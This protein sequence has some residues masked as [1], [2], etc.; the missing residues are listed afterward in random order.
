MLYEYGHVFPIGLCH[1]KRIAEVVEDPHCD[2]PALVI[3]ECQDLL[4][5]IAEKTERIEAKTKTLKAPAA[6][7]DT[8]RRL[9]TMP[10]VPYVGNVAPLAAALTAPSEAHPVAN[11]GHFAFRALRPGPGSGE[12][13]RVGSGLHRSARLRPCGVP[14]SVR[15]GGGVV[16]RRAADP[17]RGAARTRPIR[18]RPRIFAK[19]F[20]RIT[21]WTLGSLALLILAGVLWLRQSPSR[22]GITLFAEDTRVGNFRD[23]ARVFPSRPVAR[24]GPV[25]AQVPGRRIAALAC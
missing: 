7:T 20:F 13:A 1:L 8:A 19:R 18:R 14:T 16:P 2:L 6:E 12:P 5:Q 25:W 10:G 21:A 3:A 4:A 17:L 11:A 22:A 9:Q 24:A 15:R 23:M